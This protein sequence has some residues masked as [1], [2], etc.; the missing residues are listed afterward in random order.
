M[1]QGI[2]QSEQQRKFK[3][4]KR[5]QNQQ[6]RQILQRSQIS[7]PYQ[8][9]KKKKDKTNNGDGGNDE[10]EVTPSAYGNTKKAANVSQV[11]TKT[12][13]VVSGADVDK[14]N[15]T[16]SVRRLTVLV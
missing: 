6:G 13:I 16:S 10:A 8:L 12:S 11:A 15:G 4:M 2:D 5:R 1:R 14:K 3:Q 7:C 9:G